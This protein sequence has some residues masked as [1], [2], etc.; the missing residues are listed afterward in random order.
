VEEVCFQTEKD[1]VITL[2]L[3][4]TGITLFSHPLELVISTGGIPAG[5]AFFDEGFVR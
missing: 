2:M 4:S 5:D 3:T 1:A